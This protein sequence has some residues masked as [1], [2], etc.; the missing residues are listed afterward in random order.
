[1]F[2][3]TPLVIGVSKSGDNPLGFAAILGFGQ[4]IG[5]A[6]FLFQNKYRKYL[7][8]TELL[9]Q[10]IDSKNLFLVGLVGRFAFLFYAWATAFADTVI[11]AILF[12]T[13][14][15]ILVFLRY[16]TDHNKQLLSRGQRGQTLLLLF[17]ALLGIAFVL[18]AESGS[19][20]I[21]SFGIPIVIVAAWLEALNIDRSLQFGEKLDQ[22]I[23]EQKLVY[24]IF[25]LVITNFISGIVVS[26]II[27]T[28]VILVN[29]DLSN[30]L[31]LDYMGL[32]A[33]FVLICSPLG[34]IWLRKA[35]LKEGIN[36]A[37]NSI[38]YFTPLLGIQGS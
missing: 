33:G 36:P 8:F 2:S 12:E 14:V 23:P 16:K 21:I 35:N 11:V 25:F 38:I 17:F 34:T 30:Y 37:I 20:F 19:L 1:M 6:S 22:G 9:N 32:V 3:I 28:Q 26:C 5:L 18:L 10:L 4:A 24:T 31:Q 15:I 27:A 13:R 29:N 7:D